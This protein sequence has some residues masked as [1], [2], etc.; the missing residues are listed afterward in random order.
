MKNPNAVVKEF[1]VS[2]YPRTEVALE[3]GRLGYTPNNVMGYSIRT[4]RYRYSIWLKDNTRS[5]D[6]YN[7][8]KLVGI[9]LY[10]YQVDPL[11]TINVAKEKKYASIAA[12]MHK[13]MMD[14][15]K[16]QEKA[17]KK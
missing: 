7:P 6:P 14:F 16:T 9:E 17:T 4:S 15:F 8:E 12:Q 13:K 10:D 3:L 11:E 5:T 1:S 2:Q